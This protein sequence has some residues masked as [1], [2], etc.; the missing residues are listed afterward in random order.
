MRRL[1]LI[2]A[3]LALAGSVAGTASADPAKGYVIH[4]SCNNGQSV[5]IVSI[6]Q[7]NNDAFQVVG[8]TSVVVLVGLTSYDLSGNLV[9][10]FL[11][12]GHQNQQLTKCNYIAPGF[13][14]GTAEALF[15]PI[16]A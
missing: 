5:D 4:L 8:S 1:A 6:G 2:A 16:G 3:V 11:R 10:S 13:G 15:T 12:P 7:A 9:L 14:Y